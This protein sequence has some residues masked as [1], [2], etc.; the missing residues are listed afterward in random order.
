LF[1]L[2]CAVFATVSRPNAKPLISGDMVVWK[3]KGTRG[4]IINFDLGTGKFEVHF[5]TTG[6]TEFLK[7]EDIKRVG[8][9]DDDEDV[10]GD[11]ELESGSRAGSN[12]SSRSRSRPSQPT[13]VVHHHKKDNKEKSL[14]RTKSEPRVSEHGK[15]DKDGTWKHGHHADHKGHFRPDGTWDP[16]TG[17]KHSHLHSILDAKDAQKELA[18][19]LGI[20]ALKQKMREDAE[21]GHSSDRRGSE[22]GAP[23]IHIMM[24]NDHSAHRIRVRGR[25]RA[26]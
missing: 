17:E 5:V 2:G 7:P 25:K 11:I 18:E 4:E 21:R 19:A 15:F 9:G 14:P 20:S 8:D 22:G 12:S 24:R 3:K 10:E 26:P 16:G 13:V 6:R 23:I 1:L